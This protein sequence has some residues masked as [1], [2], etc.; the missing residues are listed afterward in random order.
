MKDTNIFVGLWNWLFHR[1]K[2]VKKIAETPA[3]EPIG[4]RGHY[5]DSNGAAGYYYR[6]NQSKRRKMARRKGR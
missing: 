5:Y 2:P 4:G 1:K 6:S 3:Y